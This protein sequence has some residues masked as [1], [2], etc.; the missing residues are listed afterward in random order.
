MARFLH[1]GDWQLGMTRHFLEGEAQARYD[2]ARYDAVARL[3]ELARGEACEFM[4]VCGDVF[5]SNR[6]SRRTVLHALNALAGVPVPVYLLPGNHDPLNGAS[7][8]RSEEFTRR[9]PP[10][11][12]VLER[13]EPLE[14][15]PGV[16]LVP[17]P[18]F[19]KRP[20]T[21]L[22]A[23]A[24]ASLEPA[25]AT[26]R[27]AVAHGAVDAL[28]PDA[29]DPALI[30]LDAAEAA[31][32]DGRI[33]YLALGDRHSLTEVGATG[34][35]RYAGTPEVTDYDET[36]PGFAL[37]VDA[38]PEACTVTGH[39]VG[40]WHFLRETFEVNGAGDLAEVRRRLDELPDKR[41]TVLKLGFRG[42]LPLRAHAELEAILADA[43]DMLAAVE[44]WERTADLAVLPD[45]IDLDELGLSGFARSALDRLR[46]SAEDGAEDARDALALLYRLARRP[47]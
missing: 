25:R 3:G 18:W 23:G 14:V 11:V 4:V 33:H 1:T 9:K 8:F 39:R 21:D 13:A 28:S 10:H 32:N 42:A 19:S 16:E 6:V 24:V 7:V 45:R 5:E 36:A 29:G 41:R 15:R 44:D 2:E 17:A 34:R 38:T 20:L 30:R 47:S 40:R 26:V 35:I 27:I 22:V 43:R 12:H 37:V 31:L 46:E